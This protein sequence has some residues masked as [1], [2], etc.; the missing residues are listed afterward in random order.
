MHAEMAWK[1]KSYIEERARERAYR[2][3]VMT[4]RKTENA[5]DFSE[6]GV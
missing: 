1:V 3:L 4:G 6:K 5:H 2:N